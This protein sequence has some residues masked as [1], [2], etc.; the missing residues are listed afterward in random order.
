M[1]KINLVGEKEGL[2]LSQLLGQRITL[3]CTNYFYT[4]VL[5]GVHETEVLLQQPAIVYE[6]GAWTD[7]AWKDV[8]ALPQD[9]YVRL[10]AVEAYGV[11][12]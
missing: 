7:K 8:Q 3:L 2:G 9:L 1:K 12:K 5:A 6:T 10:S 11:M 4:G